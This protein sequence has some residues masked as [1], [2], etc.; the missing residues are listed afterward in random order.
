MRNKL[1]P[2]M[3]NNLVAYMQSGKYNH[4]V[5]KSRRRIPE[6]G[7]ECNSIL[8]YRPT[9]LISIQNHGVKSKFLYPTFLSFSMILSFWLTK[10]KE[11]LS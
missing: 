4:F 9:A 11:K 8:K 7:E 10:T 3:T 2:E 6:K 1:K 5:R